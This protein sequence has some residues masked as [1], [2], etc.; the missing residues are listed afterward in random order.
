QDIHAT[1]VDGAM[2]GPEIEAHAI[3]TVL[4]SVPL[5]DAGGWLAVVAILLA[6]VVPVLA[7]LRLVGM[8]ALGLAGGLL[9]GYLVASQLAFDS[10]RVL[11]VIYPS[12]TLAVAALGGLGVNYFTEIRERQRMR[13]VFGR[14]VPSAVV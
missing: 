13:T 3:S 7:A 6:A 10:G 4:R 5:R 9:A 11:S 8:G 14:F 1:P 2:P 12:V